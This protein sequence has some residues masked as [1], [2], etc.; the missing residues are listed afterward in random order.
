VH[1][2]AL[3]FLLAV[4]AA[5]Q[6]WSLASRLASPTLYVAVDSDFAQRLRGIVGA[7]AP[8][9]LASTRLELPLAELALLGRVSELCQGTME[10][11]LGGNAGAIAVHCELPSPALAKVRELVDDEAR[12]ERVDT[13]GDVAIAALRAPGQ[14]A[15]GVEPALFLALSGNHLLVAA[16]AETVRGLLTPLTGDTLA[17]DTDFKELSRHVDGGR[18]SLTIYGALAGL[19]TAASPAVRERAAPWLA[20]SGFLD[21]RSFLVAVRESGD[22]LAS[23]VL[24]RRTSSDALDGWLAWVE[25]VPLPAL[26]ADL[27]RG[28]LG[29]LT[30]AFAPDKLR[31]RT[32]GPVVGRFYDALAGRCA[33]LGVSLERQLLQ[34]L[35]GTVGVQF[36][37]TPGSVASAYVAKAKSERDAQRLLSEFRRNGGAHGGLQVEAD[38]GV[39]ELVLPYHPLLRGRPRVGVLRDTVVLSVE[40]GVLERVA[41]ADA[42]HADARSPRWAQQA[43]KNLPGGTNQLVGGALV[44]DLS[45]LLA[46]ADRDSPLRQHVG[47]IRIQPDHIRLELFSRL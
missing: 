40:R 24:M 34:R 23:T 13:V 35:K 10:V 44:V 42:E 5:G 36:L 31:R 19:S 41:L 11:A 27:P 16:A 39:D 9:R 12:V 33:D 29:S 7:S 6:S 1:L 30:L 25:R 37:A 15:A 46:A 26:L 32:A 38:Q 17:D 47:S 21:A 4:P 45:P 8:A 22:G 18:T 2:A 28:G 3:S 14:R 20:A 43:F